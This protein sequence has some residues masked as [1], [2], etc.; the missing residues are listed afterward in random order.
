MSEAVGLRSY[1]RTQSHPVLGLISELFGVNVKGRA[2]ARPAL[3]L[4]FHPIKCRD[5]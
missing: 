3:L 2:A 4:P 5:L 1:V